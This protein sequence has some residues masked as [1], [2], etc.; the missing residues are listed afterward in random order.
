MSGLGLT[1]WCDIEDHAAFN[2]NDVAVYHAALRVLIRPFFVRDRVDRVFVDHAEGEVNDLREGEL[3][4]FHILLPTV[5][6]YRQR[7]MLATCDKHRAALERRCIGNTNGLIVRRLVVAKKI[8]IIAKTKQF[9]NCLAYLVRFN[10]ISGLSSTKS[11]S[12]GGL[13]ALRF[14]GAS[15]S[16]TV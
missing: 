6:D 3:L 5:Y 1:G 11:A 13:V 2:G 9:A 14:G 15:H 12:F 4:F 7:L 8:H 10:V 16:S